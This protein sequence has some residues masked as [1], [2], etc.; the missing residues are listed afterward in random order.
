MS[1]PR[2]AHRILWPGYATR[3]TRNNLDGI[4]ALAFCANAE[5]ISRS[6]RPFPGAV[7]STPK[8]I[9]LVGCPLPWIRHVHTKLGFNMCWG[10]GS[11]LVCCTFIG[12]LKTLF[13]RAYKVYAITDTCLCTRGSL[14]KCCLI[15]LTHALGSGKICLN[16][17]EH[18]HGLHFNHTLSVHLHVHL[19]HRLQYN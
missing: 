4:C 15:Y 9:T 19:E 5:H 7:C 2:H 1:L 12:E 6:L 13:Q 16:T 11:V 8:T 14:E 18:M 17:M 3:A 10:G